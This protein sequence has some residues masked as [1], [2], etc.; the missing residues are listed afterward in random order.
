VANLDFD[1]TQHEPSA[2]FSA[3]PAGKYQ[4]VIIESEMKKTKA[5]NGEYLQ[6]TMQVVDGE[7]KG[8]K[9]WDRLNIRNANQTAQ[10][11]ALERLSAICRA[12]GT[13]KPKDSVELHNLPLIATVAQRPGQDG[14]PQNEIKGY[15]GKPQVAPQAQ[16][17][18]PPWGRK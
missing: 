1:A 10:K 17:N 5:G 2:D 6:L 9:L 13:M 12:V 16:N 3:L 14:T 4:V 18:T 8:R 7:Y 11:I 15:S